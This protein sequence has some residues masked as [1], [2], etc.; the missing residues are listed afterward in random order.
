MTVKDRII[1]IRL[2]D[3]INKNPETAKKLGLEDKTIYDKKTNTIMERSINEQ[4]KF[5]TSFSTKERK[6]K[7]PLYMSGLRQ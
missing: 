1:M 7:R 6:G 4:K 3:K 5:C 2:M